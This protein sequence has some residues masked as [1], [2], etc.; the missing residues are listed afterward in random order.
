M[1]SM[2]AKANRLTT[3]SDFI[4]TVRKGRRAH[5]GALT[6]FL[7]TSQSESEIGNPPKFGFQVSRRVGGSVVRHRV[8]RQLRHLIAPWVP[9]TPN[10]T[11][12]VIRPNE[13]SK[14]F[15]HDVDLLM[16]R[17]TEVSGERR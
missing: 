10:S 14:D 4:T 15:S 7:F 5:V 11:M 17:L 2:L 1:V 3:K 16:R 8:V 6:G 13:K 9:L 12:V